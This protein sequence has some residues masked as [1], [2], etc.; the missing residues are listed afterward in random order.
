MIQFLIGLACGLIL[1]IPLAVYVSRRT[2]RRVRKLED[3][4]RGAERLAELG[5]L[6]GGLAHEIKNPLS[7]VGLNL[8]LLSESLDDADIP[9][10]LRRRLNSRISSLT[11]ET[12]RLRGILED[13]LSFA[14]RVRIDP[15]PT[16]INDLIDQLADFYA[17][18]AEASGL[19]FRTQLDPKA[20]SAQLDATLIKQ[21]LLNLLINATQAMVEARYEN[22]PHGGSTELILT[23]QPLDDDTIAIHVIDTGPGIEED[24]L[25]RIFHPY[26]TTKRDG[27]GLGLSTTRRIIH[28]HG[29]DLTVHS[30]V[31]QGSDFTIRLQRRVEPP[32]E[33]A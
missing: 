9:D 3:R 31:G 33:A 21:A 1:L 24:T 28:E 27:T 17:P 2:A 13:F 32:T 20:G 5:T 14:G 25:Q 22:T 18:Q 29:G 6:T 8:Q 11:D 30:E 23:T 12:Q 19:T 15:Q 16:D 26:F 10:A 4:A 7:T